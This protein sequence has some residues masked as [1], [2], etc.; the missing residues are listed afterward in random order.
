MKETQRSRWILSG[1]NGCVKYQLLVA[2]GTKGYFIEQVVSDDI[3]QDIP[4][5]IKNRPNS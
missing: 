3:E 5:I 1:E 4:S 2:Q